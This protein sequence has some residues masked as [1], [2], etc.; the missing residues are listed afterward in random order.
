MN[1]AIFISP[2][3]RVPPNEE[4]ILAPWYLAE[5]LVNGLADRKKTVYLFAA[6][7]SQTK[8]ILCDY[9]IEPTFPMR[10][11]FSQIEYK[12]YVKR[13]DQLL[14]SQMVDVS[15][16]KSIEVVHSH[17]LENVYEI[18]SDAPPSL[19]F[20][21]TLHDPINMDKE[22]LIAQ[23]NALPNCHFVSISDAQRQNLPYRFTDTVYNGIRLADWS[24]Q[25]E[26]SDYLLHMGRLVPEK[27]LDDAI[28]AAL[29]LNMQLEIGTDFSDSNIDNDYYRKKIEPYLK[30]PLIGEPGIVTGNE[31]NILYKQARALLFP[32]KWEEPFGLVMT[33]AMACGTP[34]VAYGRGSAPEVVVDG[35]TGFI[36]N[37]SEKEKRGNWIV[38]KPGVDGLVEALERINAMDERGYSAMREACRQ[39]VEDYFSVKNM[40]IGYEKVYNKILG[41]E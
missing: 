27:G 10:A 11:K 4:K 6:K 23:L 13:M 28:V 18:I 12:E 22:R 19:Q 36:V 41:R 40:V 16:E 26:P 29:R 31:K 25:A 34:V 38:K 3:H 24:F 20:V 32:I 21:F 30:N 5:D 15:R 7:T 14:F 39:H 2:R 17:Q 8:G 33:E 35:I 37:E 9:G 1:I